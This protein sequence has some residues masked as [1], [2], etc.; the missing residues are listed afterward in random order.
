MRFFLMAAACCLV[1]LTTNCTSSF[2]LR[3]SEVQYQDNGLGKNQPFAVA[4]AYATA[5]NADAATYDAET[6][7][8]CVEALTGVLRD[9][10]DLAPYISP[11]AQCGGNGGGGYGYGGGVP[12][13]APFIPG[14]IPGPAGVGI[15]YPNGV[16]WPYGRNPNK[17]V[18]DNRTSS[19][20]GS[21]YINGQKIAHCLS[22]GEEVW[23]YL[24]F[25]P[26]ERSE[27]VAFQVN[28]AW[29]PDANCQ[30]TSSGFTKVA[31]HFSAREGG[32]SYGLIRR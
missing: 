13:Q 27:G 29:F 2:S 5:K 8:K 1:V 18:L 26:H 7:A 28:T 21:V 31:P 6:R 20:Y 3:G 19:F 12:Y 24:N 16:G 25:P 4:G 15:G 23:V 32:S 9:R 17:L 30:G 11:A 14:N 22:P 10:P